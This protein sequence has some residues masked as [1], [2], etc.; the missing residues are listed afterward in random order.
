MRLGMGD[1]GAATREEQA[2]YDKQFANIRKIEHLR[3]TSKETET[4][5]CGLRLIPMD[6][7]LNMVISFTINQSNYTIQGDHGI[8]NI[9]PFRILLRAF[10]LVRGTAPE[11]LL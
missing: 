11:V 6:M 10:H 3:A 1:R 4:V 8:V 5:A 7:R 2:D 9:S